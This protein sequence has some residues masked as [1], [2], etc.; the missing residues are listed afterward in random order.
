MLVDRII[1]KYGINQID[2]VRYYISIFLIGVMCG[3][4]MGVIINE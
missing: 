2:R 3:L 1:S 4:V